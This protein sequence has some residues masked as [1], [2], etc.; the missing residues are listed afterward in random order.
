MKKIFVVLIMVAVCAA[1]GSSSSVD[2]AIS[3]IEKALDKAEKNKGKM[4]DEDWR[5]LEKEVEEPLK[6]I[7]DALEKD[8]LKLMEKMKIVAV[9]AKWATTVAAAGI[10]EMVKSTSGQREEWVQ[11]L[12]K[13]TQ[14]LDGDLGKELEKAIQEIEK[15][16]QDLE[17]TTK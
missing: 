15:V 10:S 2:K 5:S 13:A 6:V 16:V 12:E 3:Q 14:D 1:C 8:E 4:T 11:E 9:S 7:S 17:K